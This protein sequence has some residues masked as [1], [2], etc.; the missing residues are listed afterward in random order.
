[1]LRARIWSRYWMVAT[2]LFHHVLV[3]E[4][5]VSLGIT[6]VLG[7]LTEIA[8]ESQDTRY[9]PGELLLPRWSAGVVRGAD[10]IFEDAVGFAGEAHASFALFRRG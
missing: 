10:V 6:Q 5:E 9:R 8:L 2:E 4:V 7:Q 3:A 1:L